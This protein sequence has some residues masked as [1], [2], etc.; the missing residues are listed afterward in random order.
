MKLSSGQLHLA[1]TSQF[2]QV[3][4]RA[5]PFLQR[6]GGDHLHHVVKGEEKDHHK[7]SGDFICGKAKADLSLSLISK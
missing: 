2:I 5:D 1:E 4:P 7:A 3:I 6:G